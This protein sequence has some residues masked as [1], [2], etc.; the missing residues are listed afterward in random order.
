MSE[1]EQL[2]GVYKNESWAKKVDRMSDEQVI[3]I[4]RRLKSQG[5]L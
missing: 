1:R 2:K 3:A 4:Y 5:K